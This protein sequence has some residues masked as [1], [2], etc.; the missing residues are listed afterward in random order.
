MSFII[1]LDQTIFCD[2]YMDN[3]TFK[4]VVKEILVPYN[5][6]E[7]DFE[8]LEL[9]DG[10]LLVDIEQ[11]KLFL[12]WIGFET[13]IHPEEDLIMN[14]YDDVFLTVKFYDSKRIVRITDHLFED[15]GR[16]TDDEYFKHSVRSLVDEHNFKS[17]G[18]AGGENNLISN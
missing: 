12:G 16:I 3:D 11:Q 1:Y 17:A 7:N 9:G 13:C 10:K 2:R 18:E 6:W 4:Q 15:A 14:I 5:R 8:D